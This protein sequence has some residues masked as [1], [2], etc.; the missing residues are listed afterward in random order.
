MDTPA[1]SEAD[2]SKLRVDTLLSIFE[3]ETRVIE[4]AYRYAKSIY[5]DS[6]SH[7]LTMTTALFYTLYTKIFNP[8]TSYPMERIP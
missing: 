1:S 3:M 4:I 7:R 6:P 5:M 8:F 2:I